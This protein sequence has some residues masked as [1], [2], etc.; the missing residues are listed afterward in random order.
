[1]GSFGFLHVAEEWLTSFLSSTALFILLEGFDAG[2]GIFCSL[3]LLLVLVSITGSITNNT[4]CKSPVLSG[5]LLENKTGC[6]A[7]SAAERLQGGE[8]G[9][10][11]LFVRLQ[12]AAL[13]SSVFGCSQIHGLLWQQGMEEEGWKQHRALLGGKGAVGEVR[14]SRRDGGQ[15]WGLPCLQPAAP[16]EQKLP[17]LSCLTVSAHRIQ[18]WAVL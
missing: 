1:M 11:K 14:S 5:L 16:S 8:A 9:R 10:G 3:G 13:L 2:M 12:G 15:G 6:S 17:W 4:D 7:F 18:T